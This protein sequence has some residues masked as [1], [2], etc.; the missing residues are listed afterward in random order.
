[1]A[2]CCC[3]TSP[4]F[5]QLHLEPTRRASIL[6]PLRRRSP[7]L[8]FRCRS[9]LPPAASVGSSAADYP[10]S[11]GR[12]ADDPG[13]Q[14]AT[15][16]R[17]PRRSVAGV[18]Q[19]ELVDHKELAD[20]DSFFC[21]FNGVDLHHRICHCEEIDEKVGVKI[22]FVLLHGFGASAFSWDRIMRPLARMVKSK[23]LAFDRPAFGLTSRTTVSRALNPYS[24]TFSVLATLFFI[25][26]IAASKTGDKEKKGSKAI[27]MGHSAG[28]L[29]AVETYFEA[30]EKVAALILVAP[31]II[32]PLAPRRIDKEKMR[33]LKE[34]GASKNPFMRF[35][36]V[37]ANISM[38]LMRVAFNMLKAMRDM[39]GSL[40]AR[41]LSAFLRSSLALML[42]RM[43]MDKFGVLAIRNAWFDPSRITDYVIQ[44]YTKPL[45]V[46]GWERALLEYTLA[47]LTE[48][49]TKPP[50]SERLAQISCPVLIVTGD[51]DRL[52]PAWNAERLSRV[53]PGSS[54][55]VIKHC[56]HLPHEEKVEEFLVI[57]ER[58]LQRVFGVADSQFV[59]A[60]A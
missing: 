43:I 19:E 17:P 39:V 46:K 23:V 45:R 51:N 32:A 35:L 34:N 29:V 50:L 26:H 36:K 22:P 24:M 27:L 12:A 4:Q 38:Q 33:T 20:A 49:S 21:E 40:Y 42:V 6:R 15:A 5:P 10:L 60:A 1:M 57:V 52:V 25:D 11:G 41:A 47:L 16:R 48:S 3:A 56:G 28:C 7:S 31:A 59:P 8:S 37:L 9:L 44:G 18:D 2:V 13:G 14:P 55:E 53:I 58:F 54:F 30:P